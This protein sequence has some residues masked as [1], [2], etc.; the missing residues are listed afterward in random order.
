M[1]NCVY[2]CAHE[3]T[4]PFQGQPVKKEPGT[5]ETCTAMGDIL[6]RIGDKWSVMMVGYL[7]HKT[8]AL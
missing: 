6:N 3:S 8:H 5:A 7:T 4:T 2:I 1:S